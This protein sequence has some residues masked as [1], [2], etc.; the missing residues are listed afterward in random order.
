MSDHDLYLDELFRDA[1]VHP[2]SHVEVKL[3]PWCRDVSE[4]HHYFY[5]NLAA[6]YEAFTTNP[7][8]S[9][10]VV[11]LN[12]NVTFFSSQSMEVRKA[13]RQLSPGTSLHTATSASPGADAAARSKLEASGDLD[14]LPGSLDENTPANAAPLRTGV[15]NPQEEAHPTQIPV[16]SPSGILSRMR[17]AIG[18]LIAREDPAA[19]SPPSASEAAQPIQRAFIPLE[20]STPGRIED[21]TDGSHTATERQSYFLQT[22][23]PL[24]KLC[25]AL[26]PIEMNPLFDDSVLA[27][28]RDDFLIYLYEL[29]LLSVHLQLGDHLTGMNLEICNVYQKVLRITVEQHI[30]CLQMFDLISLSSSEAAPA[31]AGSRSAAP[32]SAAAPA[33]SRFDWDLVTRL[34]EQSPASS[35]FHQRY[36]RLLS[37]MVKEEEVPIAVRA[38]IYSGCLVPLY[39]VVPNTERMPFTA[40][41]VQFSLAAMKEFLAIPEEI[42]PYCH[43]QSQRIAINHIEV[44]SQCVVLRSMAITVNQ[45][46]KQAVPGCSTALGASG[47]N[48][49]TDVS[50]YCYFVFQESLAIAM[51]PMPWL[52]SLSG[53]QHVSTTILALFIE[54]CVAIPSFL[55]SA[56]AVVGSQ[57]LYPSYY[58]NKDSLVTLLSVFL[59]MGPMRRFQASLPLPTSMSQ[60]EL[61][62]VMLDAFKMLSGAQFHSNIL[63]RTMVF[64]NGLLLPAMM[65]L[66]SC[67]LCIHWGFLSPNGEVVPSRVAAVGPNGGPVFPE[68][69][70]ESVNFFFH[71]LAAAAPPT[72]LYTVELRHMLRSASIVC[73][74]FI[75]KMTSEFMKEHNARL[76]KEERECEVLRNRAAWPTEGGGPAG[77]ESYVKRWLPDIQSLP[78]P[79]STK[80]VARFLRLLDVSADHLFMTVKLERAGQLVP[81]RADYAAME[82]LG[83][84]QLTPAED[85]PPGFIFSEHIMLFLDHECDHNGG[86]EGGNRSHGDAASEI[87]SRLMFLLD[88]S[89]SVEKVRSEALARLRDVGRVSGVDGNSM[90][91]NVDRRWGVLLDAIRHSILR[92]Y[93]RLAAYVLVTVEKLAAEGSPVPRLALY[94]CC[95]Y[96]MV[97]DPEKVDA[98]RSSGSRSLTSHPP[99]CTRKYPQ[100]TMRYLLELVEDRLQYAMRTSLRGA[101]DESARGA[102]EDVVWAP[103]RLLLGNYLGGIHYYQ[104]LQGS[105]VYYTV[106][107]ADLIAEDARL[108]Q[109]WSNLTASAYGL[110]GT[111][112]EAASEST[113]S[114]LNRS[115][116]VDYFARESRRFFLEWEGVVQHILF[117][118]SSVLIYG[119]S[120]VPQHSHLPDTS[121]ETPWSKLIIRK[122]I[123]HRADSTAAAFDHSSSTVCC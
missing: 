68:D 94:H 115:N 7:T 93:H 63:S 11:D 19:A 30:Q 40:H 18:N 122:V 70:V 121:S 118:P 86:R 38:T 107:D 72:K 47:G 67:V 24:D 99:S 64:A 45:L 48:R 53:I 10:L 21:L 6:V 95:R 15:S 17:R 81:I 39:Y 119:G 111:L 58:S 112:S 44:H 14:S 36:Q 120:G 91:K 29:L 82:K 46:G 59:S 92:L 113:F 108:I 76:M 65:Q 103:L 31:A 28:L 116:V 96:F 85:A 106:A 8:A 60:H 109:D 4:L 52:D 26:P 66:G 88:M 90:S 32:G 97:S 69:F 20:G 74:S 100:F 98:L 9:S 16:S 102:V 78:A 56:L 83:S 89:A 13:A 35:D 62:R 79:L 43:L 117:K 3:P 75:A 84:R 41:T 80:A 50:K 5:P 110:S 55:L 1:V 61:Q 49:V 23:I 71:Q 105:H 25:S 114:F 37:T 42:I 57:R 51:C 27:P 54:L 34:V 12:D 101:G 2:P 22:S 87:I 104:C 123:S 33:F 73:L 77:I